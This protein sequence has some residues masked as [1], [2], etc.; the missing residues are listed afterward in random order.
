[1]KKSFGIENLKREFLG[2]MCDTAML[3][4]SARLGAMS[5]T[6]LAAAPVMAQGFIRGFQ[7]M[8]QL[9]QLVVGFIVLIGLVGG[10][11]MVLGGLVSA[12]KKY[13]RGNDDISWAKICMQVGAGG[14]AMALGWVGIQVV[15]TLGGSASDIGKSITN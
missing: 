1:M 14:F 6:V 2:A 11:G 12:Y 3:R 4:Q 8:N 7:N 13:D 10:L 9:M 15:E 5:G